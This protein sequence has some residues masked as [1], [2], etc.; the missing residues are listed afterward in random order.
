MRPATGADLTLAARRPGRRPRHPAWSCAH[1]PDVERRGALPPGRRHKASWRGLVCGRRDLQEDTHT[2]LPLARSA[3]ASCSAAP[4]L[5]NHQRAFGVCMSVP[6]GMSHT[7]TMPL[8]AQ[9]A[10]STRPPRSSASRKA[11]VLGESPPEVYAAACSSRLR[12]LVRRPRS[13]AVCSIPHRPRQA[14]QLVRLHGGSEA[15]RERQG[16]RERRIGMMALE[17][18]L[19]RSRSCALA[20]PWVQSIEKGWHAHA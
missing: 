6:R 16:A 18:S 1:C 9:A 7:S 15:T 4:R 2:H 17:P 11:S 10:H 19:E 12:S 13:N 3:T 20:T 8:Y 5:E 14:R